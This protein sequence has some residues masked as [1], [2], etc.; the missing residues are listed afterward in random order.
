MTA[1]YIGLAFVAGFAVG[2]A[3]VCVAAN[4]LIRIDRHME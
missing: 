4:E 1:L 2:I 3:A